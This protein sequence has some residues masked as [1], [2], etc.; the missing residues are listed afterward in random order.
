MRKKQQREEVRNERGRPKKYF[1][2]VQPYLDA[3]K[4]MVR[5]GATMEILGEKLNVSVSALSEYKNEF[6]DFKDALNTSGEFADM[7]IENAFYEMAKSDKWAAYTWLKNRQPKRW[8]DKHHV[9]SQNTTT[10]RKDYEN[11]SEDEL[12]AEMKQLDEIV[13]EEMDIGEGEVH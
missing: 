2:H 8:R 3:I 12:E 11:M 6:P 5:N 13:P 1:T 10:V 7:V 4:A 9:F